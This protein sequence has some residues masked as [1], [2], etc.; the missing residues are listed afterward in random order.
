MKKYFLLLISLG[1]LSA[2]HAQVADSAKRHVVLQGASNFRD[3]GGYAT[4]DGHHVKWRQ[5]Y[6]SADI[7]KL[8]DDDLAVLKGRK[9]TYD[10]DLRG[11]QES[12]QA[13]DRLNPGTDYILSPAGSDNMDWIKSITKLKGNQADSVMQSYY[14]NTQFL[15]ERYKLFFNKLLVLPQ[16]NSLVFHC[17]AGKDRTGI[18]AALLLYSLGVPYDTI[19][20]DYL[21]SN[22][23]RRADNVKMVNQMVKYAHIDEQVA[24]EMA[25]VK[26]EFLDSTFKA[27]TDQYGSVDNFL[28]TQVG[29]DDQ[30]IGLLKKKFLE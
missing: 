4:A 29:L 12:A 30:K 11:H 9:V 24:K 27:I 8:T 26:K 6:R 13:P 2:S 15:A 1:A 21:A 25:G 20:N 5:V 14:S 7:S 23:Y 18:G 16:D 17:T 19:M 22:Y 10:V 28:K 3:L